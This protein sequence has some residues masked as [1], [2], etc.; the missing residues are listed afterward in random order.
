MHSTI[1]AIIMGV[2]EWK[3][4]IFTNPASNDTIKCGLRFG[5]LTFHPIKHNRT[6]PVTY[7]TTQSRYQWALPGTNASTDANQLPTFNREVNIEE[8]V[9]TLGNAGGVCG[10][11]VGG[12]CLLSII[13]YGAV[14]VSINVVL[15]VSICVLVVPLSIPWNITNSIRN[16]LL[17]TYFL[18]LQQYFMRFF[19]V[20]FCPL[21]QPLITLWFLN[22]NVAAKDIYLT[23]LTPD[24]GKFN[25]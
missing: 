3:V 16:K 23:H 6:K 1:F 10:I 8:G 12:I 20:Y 7:I 14:A 11:S 15:Y 5:C 4:L 17:Q 22:S 13:L 24:K 2:T 25:A 18:S 19:I 9:H 21:S